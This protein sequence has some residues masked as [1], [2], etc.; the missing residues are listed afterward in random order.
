MQVIKNLGVSYTQVINF[1]VPWEKNFN[2][3]WNYN[4]VSVGN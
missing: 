2:V 1:L 4:A 3:G